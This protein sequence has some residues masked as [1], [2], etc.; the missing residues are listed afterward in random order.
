MAPTDKFK[1]IGQ[2][3]APLTLMVV[4]V[5]VLVLALGAGGFVAFN[6]G[7][8]TKSQ[9][10]YEYQHEIMPIMSAKHGDTTAFDAENKLRKEHGEAPLQM[11]KETKGAAAKDP[12]AFKKLQEQLAAHGAGGSA[13]Q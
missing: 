2:R 9:Q 6:G 13:S 4:G 12:E 10:E 8:K 11:P 7:L 1:E 3:E 5:I